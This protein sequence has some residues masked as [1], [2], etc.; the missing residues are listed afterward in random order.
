V[1]A[2]STHEDPV[3]D[4]A[5]RSAGILRCDPS[6]LG[7]TKLDD[8]AVA[9]GSSAVHAAADAAADDKD[10]KTSA[11][12]KKNMNSASAATTPA[13]DIDSIPCWGHIVRDVSPKKMMICL[14]F[15]LPVEVAMADPVVL[16]RRNPVVDTKEA[17]ADSASSSGSGSGSG[18]QIE[19][20][21]GSSR[22]RDAEGD[23]KS[24]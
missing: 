14:S 7:L 4:I 15:R 20:S 5:A 6:L 3:A 8:T 13:V 18:S 1:Y 11:T 24:P 16:E 22:K 10:L 12:N 9:A 2:F 17:G 21:I 23:I 19:A